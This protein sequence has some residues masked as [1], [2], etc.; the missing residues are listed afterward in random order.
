[1][2]IGARGFLQSQYESL[3][4]SKNKE[5]EESMEKKER[6]LAYLKLLNDLVQVLCLLFGQRE[7]WNTYHGGQREDG[8][9]WVFVCPQGFN[10]LCNSTCS[11]TLED[12]FLLL[13]TGCAISQFHNEN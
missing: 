13:S 7:Q 9:I 2:C 8:G 6:P 5:I 4:W 11:S 3:S 1:M 12:P 10:S